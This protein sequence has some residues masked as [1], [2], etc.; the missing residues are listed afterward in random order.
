MGKSIAFCYYIPVSKNNFVSGESNQ[1][2]FFSTTFYLE[3]SF[4][5][6][7]LRPCELFILL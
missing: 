2:L 3:P 6:F 4:V 1:F 5:N 7:K